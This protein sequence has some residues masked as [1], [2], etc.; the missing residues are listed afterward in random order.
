MG[1]DFTLFA[2]INGIVKYE[3]KGRDR[4]QVS[5]YTQAV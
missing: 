5:V 4:K 2:Q 3:K 1:K